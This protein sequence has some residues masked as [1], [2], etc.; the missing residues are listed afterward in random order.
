MN[1]VG[2]WHYS[3]EMF[4]DTLY[5]TTVLQLDYEVDSF[6]SFACPRLK[7]FSGRIL[8]GQSDNVDIAI[9]ITIKSGLG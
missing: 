7:D 4:F 5:P 1:T 2:I 3:S 9:R 8:L 6:S